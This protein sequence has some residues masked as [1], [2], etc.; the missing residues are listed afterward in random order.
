MLDGTMGVTYPH[1]FHFAETTEFVTVECIEFLLFDCRT[2]L[3]TAREFE[4]TTVQPFFVCHYNRTDFT[5][6]GSSHRLQGGS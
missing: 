4:S 6:A 5:S 3:K 1:K 2:H